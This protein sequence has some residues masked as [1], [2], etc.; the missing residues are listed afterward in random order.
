MIF[1]VFIF[2]FSLEPTVREQ[3]DENDFHR[4]YSIFFESTILKVLDH[5]YFQSSL[6]RIRRHF[7]NGIWNDTLQLKIF[8]TWISVWTNYFLSKFPKMKIDESA[9]KIIHYNN[10][11]LLFEEHW[12]KTF[13]LLLYASV[14][15]NSVCLEVNSRPPYFSLQVKFWWGLMLFFGRFTAVEYSYDVFIFHETFVP[16]NGEHSSRH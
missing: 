2:I 5:S 11:S 4:Y 13:H 12:S 7:D 9:W 3:P 6:A 16:V 1:C 8:R 15:S 14:P 10:P